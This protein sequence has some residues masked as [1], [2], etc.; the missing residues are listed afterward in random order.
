M[1]ST[2]LEGA[3]ADS[4]AEQATDSCTMREEIGC[5][6]GHDSGQA[7]AEYAIIIALVSLG[8]LVILGVFR[9]AIVAVF[10]LVAETISNN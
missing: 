6:G 9:E 5:S 10:L 2:Y 7:I 3:V 8:L 4:T 1:R